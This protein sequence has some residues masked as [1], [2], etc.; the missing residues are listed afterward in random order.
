MDFVESVYY[1]LMSILA[2][3]SIN[4]YWVNNI[5]NIKYKIYTFKSFKSFMTNIRG[6]TI[7]LIIVITY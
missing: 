1:E 2:G 4:K 3:I 7:F 6:K 5:I